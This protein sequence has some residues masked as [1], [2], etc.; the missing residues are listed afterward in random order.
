MWMRTMFT[1]LEAVPRHLPQSE[2]ARD[3]AC[4][5][6]LRGIMDRSAGVDEDGGGDSERTWKKSNESP[7]LPNIAG[8]SE[9]RA[10]GT[11]W[12]RRIGRGCIGMEPV[13]RCARVRTPTQSCLRAEGASPEPRS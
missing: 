7:M 12:F 11:P 9:L 2:Q 13:S 4:H 5:E 3:L 10:T 8:S 1:D 6:N